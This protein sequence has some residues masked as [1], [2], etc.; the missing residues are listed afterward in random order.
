[1]NVPAAPL[2]PAA[3]APLRENVRRL[4]VTVGEM[5]AEQLGADFLGAVEALR[6]AAVRRREDEGALESLEA[7]LAGRPV[8]QAEALTQ[9][10]SAWFQAV[11][12]AERV[13]RIR[14]RDRKSVV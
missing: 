6:A 11:N 1:M 9:A 7:L 12:I 3:D 2:A 13:H 4:G 10:F 5:L 8:A 14:R